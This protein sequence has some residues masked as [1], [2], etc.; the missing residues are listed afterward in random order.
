MPSVASPRI[1]T[2]RRLRIA[3]SILLVVVSAACSGGGKK[4]YQPIPWRGADPIDEIDGYIDAHPVDKANPRWKLRVPRPPAMVRF[5]PNQEY[6]WYLTTS[7][8][9]IKIRLETEYAPRHVA[10]TIYLTRLGFYDGLGFHRIIP[11]FMAQ[12]G[13]PIG[14]GAGGPGFRYAGEFHK[15]ALHDERGIVS[16]A[17]AGPRTDGSQF[18]IL[19]KKAEHLDHK[20]TVFGIVVEGWGTLRSMEMLGTEKGDPRK[21][22]T[23]ERAVVGVEARQ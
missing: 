7:E 16:M 14:N 23:I 3:I 22:V 13:D 12:G 10:S 4:Q 5:D 8:G 18:F 9:L 15:K 11:G 6:F 17:N 2:Q 20:H 1:P 21:P 19:F